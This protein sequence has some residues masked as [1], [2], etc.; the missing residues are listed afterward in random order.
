MWT[1]FFYAHNKLTLGVLS[2]SDRTN[3]CSTWA[4]NLSMGGKI[5]ACWLVGDQIL[6]S[7]NQMLIKNKLYDMS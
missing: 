7:L 4:H 1:G 5:L 3:M 2:Q 6:I